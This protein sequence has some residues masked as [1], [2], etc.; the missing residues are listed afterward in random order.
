MGK[1]IY[2]HRYISLARVLA[3]LIQ[4]I[5]ITGCSS[6]F[7]ATYDIKTEEAIF[8]SAKLIDQFYGTLLETPENQ[9][10]YAKFSDIYVSIEAELNSLV[11]RNKVRTLN[12]DSIEISERILKLWQKHKER[13]KKKDTYSSGNA[14][15]DRKRF[16]RMF[17]YALRAEGAKKPD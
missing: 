14:K 16:E 12:E 2:S 8:K 11:L 3:I 1:Y 17:A 6:R 13:H 10:E 9:R 15:L 4:L 5:I 7:I